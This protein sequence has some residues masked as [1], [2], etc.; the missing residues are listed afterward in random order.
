LHLLRPDVRVAWADRIYQGTKYDLFFNSWTFVER[1]DLSSN[2][3]AFFFNPSTKT[4]G[5][6]HLRVCVRVPDLSELLVHEDNAFMANKKLQLLFKKSRPRYAVEVTLDGSL[7]Y[8]SEFIER[9]PVL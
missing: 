5:P 2:D 1:A 9:D 6:F 4:Q 8:Q 7:A 3:M